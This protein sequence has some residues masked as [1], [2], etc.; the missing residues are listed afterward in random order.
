MPDGTKPGIDDGGLAI[1]AVFRKD[2][3]ILWVMS[4]LNWEY[5]YGGFMV[6]IRTKR[7]KTVDAARGFVQE[8]R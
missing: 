3:P 5:T 1:T 7:K 2:G 6:G 8:T 4:I